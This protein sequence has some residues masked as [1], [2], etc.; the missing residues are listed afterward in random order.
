MRLKI[1][2]YTLRRIWYHCNSRMNSPV[3]CELPAVNIITLFSKIRNIN[4]LMLIC[5]CYSFQVNRTPATLQLHGI[6]L[7]ST[8][9]YYYSET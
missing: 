4:M 8:Q 9:K 3:E 5:L 7:D 1:T 6:V 2:N